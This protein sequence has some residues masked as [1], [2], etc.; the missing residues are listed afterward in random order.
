MNELLTPNNTA[1]KTHLSAVNE[2]QKD[3]NPLILPLAIP[4]DIGLEMLTT[5]SGE[6]GPDLAPRLEEAGLTF[7]W[8]LLLKVK[9]E[10]DLA[11]LE[12]RE[13]PPDLTCLLDRT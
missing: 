10:S 2:G 9:F 7:R 12:L 4:G 5:G 8:K 11:P 3:A 13:P 6:K 1:S